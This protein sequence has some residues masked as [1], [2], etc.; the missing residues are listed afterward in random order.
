MVSP[1]A[2]HSTGPMSV[3]TSSSP[4]TTTPAMAR[5]WRRNWRQAS[6]HSERAG[7]RSA[8]SVRVGSRT[9]FWA[10]PVDHAGFGQPLGARGPYV[11]LGQILEH[12]CARVAYERG[13]LK[14]AKHHDWHER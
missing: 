1:E 9:T 10:V 3:I 4:K 13:R 8:R 2:R 12:G 11:I 6:D 14:Q 5:W 7:R